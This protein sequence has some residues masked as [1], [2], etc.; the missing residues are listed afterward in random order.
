M[1]RIIFA[2]YL[3][4]STA[5]A[6]AQGTSAAPIEL[7][8]D[9]PD[10]HIVVQG[11]TLWGIAGKFLKDPLRWP[12]I[13]R[14]NSEQV[15]N[16]H[17]IY[18]GQVVILDRS[19]DQPQLRIGI[20]KLSPEVREQP[21]PKEIPAIPA[22]A[23]EPF[24]SQPLV[25]ES[26]GFLLAPRVVGT[27]ENR[28][29]VGNGDV[30]YAADVDPQIRNWQLFREGKPLTDPDT[31]EVL[32]LEAVYLGNARSIQTQGD[33]TTLEVTSLKQEILRG[34]RLVPA[35][36][37]GIMSYI[38]R[39]P[40]QPVN[41]RVLSLYGGVGE[42]GRH[43]VI[44][45]SRG[46]REGLEMGHVLALYRGG[47]TVTNRF[48]VDASSSSWRFADDKPQTHVLPDERYGLVFI[49]R[50]FEK[51]SYGLILS[52][53]RPVMSGDYVRQP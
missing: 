37:P 32:G 15:K 23:I 13:W 47:I 28:V 40:S 33:V 21:I 3:S 45:I 10:R 18:P 52:A 25:I 43:S 39:V 8:P 2:L 22:Q 38:P 36:Q 49:F 5:I 27:Q 30:V 24:L 44:A 50:V 4:F 16:P 31:K 29:V 6:F 11:D 7:A 17:R 14:M 19:G 35:N 26:N 46:T 53:S 51:V 34:D 48:T 42:G 1:R 20:V 9:A 12:D 41:G